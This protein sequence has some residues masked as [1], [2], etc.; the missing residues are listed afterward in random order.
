MDEARRERWQKMMADKMEAARI[1]HTLKV[2][3]IA[4]GWVRPHLIFR[5]FYFRLFYSSAN[6]QGNNHAT[7]V[8]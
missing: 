3:S 7:P 8:R 4:I 2:G 6:V 5:L 1:E